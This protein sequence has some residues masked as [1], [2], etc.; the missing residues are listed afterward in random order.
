MS[1]RSYEVALEGRRMTDG[2]GDPEK[3]AYQP[4]GVAADPIDLRKF[5]DLYGKSLEYFYPERRRRPGKTK[6]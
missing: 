1:K 6:P 2:K 5:A 3:I 4:L